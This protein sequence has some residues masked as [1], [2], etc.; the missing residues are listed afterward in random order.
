MF[1]GISI[2]IWFLAIVLILVALAF[3]F[4]RQIIHVNLVAITLL[5]PISFI[6]AMSALF[7]PVV[8]QGAAEV[9][10]SEAQFSQQ[11]KA[12]DSTLTTAGNLP[13]NFIDK[14]H[15]LLNQEN[16]DSRE[17][18]SELYPQFINLVGEVLRWVT[19]ILAFVIMLLISYTRYAF[20]SVFQVDK[21]E[22]RV[23][24]LE[25]ITKEKI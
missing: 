4:Y 11:L 10:F 7:L 5:F 23:R 25:R 6:V 13:N 24:E 21:L 22:K 15:E 3:L 8:Y 9:A 2:I 12:L 17:Y 1:L 16:T 20:S 14:I 19:F 18:K